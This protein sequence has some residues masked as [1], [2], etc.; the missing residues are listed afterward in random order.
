MNNYNHESQQ[1]QKC[2]SLAGVEIGF[3]SNGVFWVVTP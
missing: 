1:K 3:V 2:L